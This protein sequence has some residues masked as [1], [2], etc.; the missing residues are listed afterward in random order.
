MAENNEKVYP[1]NLDRYTALR[2][3]REAL[4]TAPEAVTSMPDYPVRLAL[5]TIAEELAGLSYISDGI[6]YQTRK[7]S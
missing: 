5:V 1:G 4:E 7:A 6:R 3:Q 2:A